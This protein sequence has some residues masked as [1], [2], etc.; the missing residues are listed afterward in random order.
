MKL[1][2]EEYSSFS[3]SS[4]L[5]ILEND[6]ILLLKKTTDAIH[7]LKVYLLYD[8]YVEVYSNKLRQKTLKIDPIWN[9]QLFAFLLGTL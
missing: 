2:K 5:K 8:F 9:E 7:E 1:T 6:G 3:L 4:R